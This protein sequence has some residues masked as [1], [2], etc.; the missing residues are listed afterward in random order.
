MQHLTLKV[1]LNVI[2]LNNTAPAVAHSFFLL[3][4]CLYFSVLN[5]RRTRAAQKIT[6]LNIF[7][8]SVGWNQAEFW[9][10][11]GI[12]SINVY[13]YER[14]FTDDRQWP[15]FKLEVNFVLST[16]DLKFS[17]ISLPPQ[18][19]LVLWSHRREHVVEVHQNVNEVVE[20]V[21]ESRVSTYKNRQR[22]N[23]KCHQSRW[24][25]HLK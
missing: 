16:Y 3:S 1:K 24:S 13:V 5:S 20:N 14:R 4:L 25:T 7:S 23:L 8:R 19:L 17:H 22:L 2:A 10:R 18:V 11:N 15:D 21:G 12:E 6:A 9:S